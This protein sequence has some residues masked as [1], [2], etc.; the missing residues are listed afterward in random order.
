MAIFFLRERY[1]HGSGYLHRIDPCVKIVTVV[2]FAFAILATRE[3][4]WPAFA[5]FALFV[6]FVIALSGL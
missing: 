1:Q 4:D 2:L 3:G 5:G 6:A